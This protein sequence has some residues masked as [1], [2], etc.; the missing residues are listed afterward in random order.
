MN[1]SGASLIRIQGEESVSSTDLHRI[2]S[3]I[4]SQILDNLIM[5][6]ATN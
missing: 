5:L 1:T 2:L 4:L 6:S 3:Q